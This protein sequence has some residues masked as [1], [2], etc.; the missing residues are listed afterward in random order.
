MYNTARLKVKK[1]C[2]TGGGGCNELNFPSEYNTDAPDGN[3]GVPGNT[4]N[5]PVPSKTFLFVCQFGH[6]NYP[7]TVKDYL[8]LLDAI[9]EELQLTREMYKISYTF[10][11]QECSMKT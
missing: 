9:K 3:T 1:H 6:K 7:L 11:G 10:A 8:D 2:L 4:I 5:A